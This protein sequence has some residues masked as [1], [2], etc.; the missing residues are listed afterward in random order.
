[1]GKLEVEQC[2]TCF[3]DIFGKNSW[4]LRE[5]YGR[6]FLVFILSIHCCFLVKLHI[7][8]LWFPLGFVHQ[9]IHCGYHFSLTNWNMSDIEHWKNNEHVVS[10]GCH[11]YV[12]VDHGHLKQWR[13]QKGP[14]FTAEQ[15]PRLQRAR[16]PDPGGGWSG[17]V[18][19]TEEPWQTLAHCVYKKCRPYLE[20]TATHIM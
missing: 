15:F 13:F 3:F 14:H 19:K 9:K 20:Y 1:M 10:R 12:P 2:G 8:R 7:E 11:G 17:S 6:N 16:G 4:R 5:M 18:E